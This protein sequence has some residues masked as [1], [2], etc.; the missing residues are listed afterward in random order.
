MWV[1]RA[2]K[3]GWSTAWFRELRFAGIVIRL[4]GPGLF[5]L[6]ICESDVR[7][8]ERVATEDRVFAPLE[9]LGAVAFPLAVA[10]GNV[11][12][13]IPDAMSFSSIS[14]MSE[15]LPKSPV[16]GS[17]TL[18]EPLGGVRSNARYSALV[19]SKSRLLEVPFSSINFS[20]SC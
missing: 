15:V 5:D 13:A 12:R 20:S 7:G 11:T 17:N 16:A 19:M 18:S 14:L 6:L 9:D 2:E 3:S 8:V 10:P 4:I 1:A